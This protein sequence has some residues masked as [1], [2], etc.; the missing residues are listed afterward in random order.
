MTEDRQVATFRIA[1]PRTI[2]LRLLGLPPGAAPPRASTLAMIDEGAA[3]AAHLVDARAV[4]GFSHAGLPGSTYLPAHVP[5]VAVVCTIGPALE[6]RVAGLAAA[7]HS[8]RA[9]VLDALGSAAAEEVA[10]ASNRLVRQLALPTDLCPGKRRSPGYGSWDIREQ[11]ALF[12]FLAPAEIGVTLTGGC[13]MVPR[14]SVSYVV[15]LDGEPLDDDAVE[16]GVCHATGCQYRDP[17]R[18]GPAIQPS[19]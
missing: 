10:E 6:A 2:A 8:A 11:R 4:L 15:R 18:P 3:E 7:G 14:K 1:I 5:L 13:M 17:G 19:R 9:A 16:C 12:A